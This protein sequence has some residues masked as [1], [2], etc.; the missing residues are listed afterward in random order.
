MAEGMLKQKLSEAGIAAIDVS[1]AGVAAF[2]GESATP[3]TI[4][5]MLARGID[6]RGHASRHFSRDMALHASLIL[7]M[8]HGHKELVFSRMPDIADKTFVLTEY[9]KADDPSKSALDIRDPYGQSLEEYIL[10][11]DLIN[12]EIDRIFSL[13]RGI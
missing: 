12:E 10:C 3:Q 1:S 9:G 11:A 7:T 5:A 4:A 6:V 13:L 2:P 8:T